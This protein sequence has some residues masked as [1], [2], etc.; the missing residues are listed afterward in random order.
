M[1][2]HQRIDI[3]LSTII[4]KAAQMLIRLPEGLAVKIPMEHDIR[5]PLLE[6]RTR[7]KTLQSENGELRF[8]FLRIIDCFK[9]NQKVIILYCLKQV[10]PLE[11][12]KISCRT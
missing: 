5:S 8:S 6:F 9:R 4:G 12:W 10:L 1:L 2:R 3:L 11:Y 7:T